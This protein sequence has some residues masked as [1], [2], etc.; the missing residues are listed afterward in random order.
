MAE[1]RLSANNDT[2]VQSWDD[3]NDWD[4]V[5]GEAG[6]DSIT[7]YQGTAI[8]GAGNDRIEFLPI[9]GE[10]WRGH[11]VAY[12]NDNGVTANLAEGWANDGFGGRDTLI[13]VD[14][15]HG[16]GG[17]DHFTG[18][19]GDNYFWGNGGTDTLNG[20]AGNDG[21][22]I[23]WFQPAGGQPGRNARLEDLNVSVS[24]DG[25]QATVTLKAGTGFSYSLRDI[26]YF[27]VEGPTG[28]TPVFLGSLIKPADMAEDVI[29][30]GPSFRWNVS[31]PLG[32]A[33]SLSYSF[34]TTA[35]TSGVGAPGF[36]AFSSAEQQLVRDILAE[37]SALTGITFTERVESGSTVGQLRF[38]V[39]Q[40][41][42]TQGVTWMPGQ[43]GAGSLAGDVWMDVESMVGLKVGSEGYLAL[44][45]EIGHALGLRHTQNV[46]AGDNWA[47]ELREQDDR[48]ALTV[49]SQ[50]SSADGLFRSEWG[51]LDV[52]ALRWLYGQR[53]VDTANTVHKLGNLN[54][55][56][57]TTITDDGGTDTLDASA[58][59]LGVSLNLM[60]GALSSVGLSPAG[61]AGV[62]NLAITA[63]TVIENA[64]GSK[65]D[66]VIIG[67][68]GNNRITGG[69][70][71]DWIEGGK[72]NDTA[73]FAGNYA[74]YKI[75]NAYGKVFVEAK[76]GRSGFD[77]L[78]EVESMAF[79]DRTVA[80]DRATISGTARQGETLTATAAVA[81]TAGNGPYSYQWR[82]G[83]N[84]IAGATGS[85]LVLGQS[86]VNQ[87]ISVTIRWDD[88]SGNSEFLVSAPTASVANVNDLPV[89]SVRISGVASVGQTLTAS[90]TLTDADGMGDVS[91]QWRVGGINVGPWGSSSYVV[92][93]ADVGKAVTVVA[94]YWDW[95]GT[96]ESVTSSTAPVAGVSRTGTTAADTLT[97]DAG[98]NV[99]RGLE[100]ND[101]LNGQAGKDS[102]DGGTGN[103]SLVGGTGNDIYVVDS[104]ADVIS[105]TS[106]L[107]G[108]IDNVSSS[109]TWTLGANLEKLTLTGSS[110]IHGTGNTLAN[111]ITGNDSLVGG[112]GND[113]YVVDSTADVISETSTLAGEID[114]V[115]SSVTWTLGANLEKL[116]LTG[117]SAI[118]G[119]GNTLANTI[120][121][122]TGNNKLTGGAGNDTLSGGSGNDTLDG[123]TGNDSLVGAA[124][125]DSYFVDSVGDRIN[126]AT[127]LASEIDT[128]TSSVTWTLGSYLEK[129][130]LAGSSAIH[131]TG[132][133]LANTITGN[134]GSNKLTG[135]AGNDTLSGGSGNDTLEGGTGN[136][137]LVGGAGADIFRLASALN[138]STNVDR[139]TDFS[140]VDDV[141]QL[142]N[143]VFTQLTATGVLSSASFVASSTGNAVDASDRVL[144]ETDTGK[145]F[146]DADGSGTAVKVLVATLTTMPALTSA[147]IFVT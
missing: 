76:D 111:T 124:G 51:P 40:Q 9:A 89:G 71:N 121:G 87:F 39:S 128:V 7:L 37:T 43:A 38:G 86:L 140:T 20:G 66:D 63:T 99:L 29:A 50:E 54:A 85:T 44:L 64:V 126:E 137:S 10:P 100:G 98:E 18:H 26:E 53:G 67:N 120:T 32:S 145:L 88:D 119:T 112:T 103:D 80:V 106:T 22:G 57:Q 115:S 110:A 14:K 95:T 6:N 12:W 17:N 47:M 129:L 136:D 58:L 77:T 94:N 30:A 116:T 133:T 105:E 68:D 123:G 134:T 28:W 25:R 42:A 109:V 19:S 65:Y 142:E 23:G 45:H 78:I 5:Y 56:S 118:H 55:T 35:P 41:A 60:P 93:A 104:T 113:I 139:I 69:L 72:G 81:D 3:R 117:S 92:Q 11:E 61:F 74:D 96:Q 90:H 107:A 36:R 82:A 101:T 62:D 102:L 135:G 79:A 122:N 144:Y 138:G 143:S 146:Y 75:S 131:G 125:N 15:L 21:I 147:D 1:I 70:G 91:F 132:N 97:G 8:G 49:M 33:V 130:T 73:V 48:T 16:S 27:D 127:T 24:A 141:L 114:N 34:V 31:Q 84:D 108:E 83:S 2:Y 13:G 52:L 46:D 4:Q 59:T